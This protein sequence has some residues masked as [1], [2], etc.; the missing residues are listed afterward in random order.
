VRHLVTGN[1]EVIKSINTSL[2]LDALRINTELSRSDIA[3][4]TGLTTGT[5]SNISSKLLELGLIKELGESKLS[6]GG[7]K[8]VL[9]SLNEEGA[10]AIAVDIRTSLIEVRLVDLTAKTINSVQKNGAL[11]QDEGSKFIIESIKSLLQLHNIAGKLLGIGISIPGWVDYRVG[12]II[13]VPNLLGWENYPI[14]QELED[15][16]SVPVYI[17]ND[18]NL[19]ALAELWF[20][21]GKQHNQMIYILVEDGIGTGIILNQQIYRGYGLSVGE[22]GHI[23]LDDKKIQCGCGNFG[24]LDTVSSIKAITNRYQEIANR[25]IEWEE[26]VEIYKQDTD[27]LEILTE[28]GEKL[29]IA[30]SIIVNLFSPEA[31][32]FGGRLIDSIPSFL[33]TVK[34][35][36]NENAVKPMLQEVVVYS[37]GLKGI[38]TVLGAVALVFQSTLQ[39]YTLNSQENKN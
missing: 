18:A 31:I 33:T 32:I 11:S 13:K 22:L 1:Y 10:F 27:A 28:A 23:P 17:E 6:S 7:R 37:S 34:D 38:N 2:V 3:R 4:I 5:I 29:G 36:M 24:C 35:A 25:N 9:L 39:P 16:F 15:I 30:A 20:G 26:F 12:K 14:K 21:K 8:P 19:S